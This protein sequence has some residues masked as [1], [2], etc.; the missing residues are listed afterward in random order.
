MTGFDS[1]KPEYPRLSGVLLAII[2][3]LLLTACGD[4]IITTPM[5]KE[6]Q[7]ARARGELKGRAFSLCYSSTLHS[8]EDLM[9]R[10]N[11][12]CRGKAER[13][14]DDTIL[15]DCPLFAPTRVSFVCKRK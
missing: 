4:E 3:G 10:A 1:A 14:D 7:Q 2:G 13:L 8:E 9:D 5:P 12:L 15:N 6:Y 11:E